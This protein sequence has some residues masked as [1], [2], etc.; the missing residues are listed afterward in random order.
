M[1]F[2]VGLSWVCGWT[3]LSLPSAER[4][5]RLQARKVASPAGN[6]FLLHDA[7]VFEICKCY[8]TECFQRHRVGASYPRETAQLKE[9]EWNGPINTIIQRDICNT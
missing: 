1:E 4:G 8:S 6:Q 9:G 3:T 7:A 2:G 5:A